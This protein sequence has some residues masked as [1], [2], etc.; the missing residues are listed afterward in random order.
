MMERP[1]CRWLP[2]ED[3]HLRDMWEMQGLSASQCAVRL[4]VSRNAVIGRVGRLKL[5][6]PGSNV[7]HAD[8]NSV[9][10]PRKHTLRRT[11]NPHKFIWEIGKPPSEGP[12]EPLGP[13]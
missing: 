3:D 13:P 10:K 8:P 7:R 12:Q 11:T 9:R 4:G 2:V 5:V 1:G 6:H